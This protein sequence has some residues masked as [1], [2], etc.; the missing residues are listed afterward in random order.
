MQLLHLALEEPS[1][2]IFT[3]YFKKELAKFGSL[4]VLKDTGNLSD[5]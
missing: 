2:N 3:E 1:P 5:D 4:K